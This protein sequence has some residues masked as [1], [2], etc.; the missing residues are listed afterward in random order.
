[1]NTIITAQSGRPIPIVNS[2][3]NSTIPA[4]QQFPFFDTASNFHQR[5]NVIPGKP[6]ILPNWNP[7]TGYLNPKAFMQPADG[8]F[9]N[10]GRNAIYGPGFWN[11]DFSVTKNF[12]LT[13]RLLLQFRFEFF[14]V[15]NHPQFA[16]P[17]NSFGS[18]SF[19]QISATPDVAQGN[20]GLGG[21]GPRVVQLAAR[22]Q[23]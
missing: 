18:A 4:N 3:D 20:P 17:G 8:T 7:A 22:F 1:L 2:L 23:F 10:L 21:G 16:L 6:F 19:G 11:A 9:G 14:N 15:F 12:N 5:P 13:E